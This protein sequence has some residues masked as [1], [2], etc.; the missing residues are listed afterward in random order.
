LELFVW[1]GLIKK[2][3]LR[4]LERVNGKKEKGGHSIPLHGGLWGG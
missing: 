1:K 4:R 3:E 2:K